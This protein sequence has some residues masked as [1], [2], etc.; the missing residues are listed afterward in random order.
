MEN[1]N[2]NCKT[3]NGPD[4][5]GMEVHVTLPGKNRNQLQ[6]LLKAKGTRCRQWKKV[7]IN[8]SFDLVT[9][10]RNKDCIPPY[11]VMN[12][13]YVHMYTYEYIHVYIPCLCCSLLHSN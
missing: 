6:C 1:Y 9:R 7:V 13:F 10:Y 2:L 3:T 5:S 12:A 4:P 11:F 8:T